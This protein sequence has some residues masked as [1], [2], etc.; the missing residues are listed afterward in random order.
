MLVPKL[1]TT[2]Q[3]YTRDQFVAAG[4]ERNVPTI[5]STAMHALQD[6]I[7][8]TRKDGTMVLLSEVDAQPWVALA[9]SGLLQEVGEEYVCNDVDDAL[10]AARKHLGLA[11]EEG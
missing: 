4:A 7:R 8:R 11:A 1:F 3:T 2:L 5:D 10:A 6:L 9:R